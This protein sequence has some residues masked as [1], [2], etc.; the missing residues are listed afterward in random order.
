MCLSLYTYQKNNLM[1]KIVTYAFLF[2]ILLAAC[3]PSIPPKLESTLS[4]MEYQIHQAFGIWDNEVERLGTPDKT[5]HSTWLDVGVRYHYA[6]LKDVVLLEN[7]KAAAKVAIFNGGPHGESINFNSENSFGYYNPDFLKEVEKAMEQFIANPISK[8][9][10]QSVYDNQ[11]KD[12]ARGYYKAYL[13]LKNNPQIPR[14][15]ANEGASKTMPLSEVTS[16]YADLVQHEHNRA[17]LG[18]P[19][20]YIQDIFESYARAMEKEGDDGYIASTAPGFWVR[21]MID[22]TSKQFASILVDVMKVYDD[23]FLESVN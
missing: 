19:G 2:T 8:S 21:R 5:T 17:T 11:L 12:L 9:L 23:A 4:P 1:K 3:T 7:L 6:A 13:F 22:G 14:Y 15:P 20:D 18:T 10:G 16:T